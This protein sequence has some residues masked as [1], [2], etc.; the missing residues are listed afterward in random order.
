VVFAKVDGE[1]FTAF[2]VER[3]TPGLSIGA[4]EHKL[5]IRGSS[6]C[7]LILE[8]AAVPVGNVLG[9]IGKGHRIAFNI[10]NVGRL[11]LGS[12]VAGGMKYQ[13][14]Q[15]LKYAQERQ[16][17][18]SPIF[19]FGLI[20]EKFARMATWTYAVESMAYRTSGLID[21][22]LAGEDPKATDYDRKTIAAIEEYAVEASILK[23]F[24]SEAVGMVVDEAVQIHGGYGFIED[25]AVARAY[26]DVRINRIFEGTNEI[27]RLLITGMLLKR[28]FSRGLPLFDF[29]QA[30]ES[31]LSSRASPQ[32]RG[33]DEVS[34]EALVAEHLKRLAVY[35]LKL[36]A[37]A[38]GPKIEE[39]QSVLA[40]IADIVMD[41]FALD[42][43]VARARQSAG[44]GAI[45][46]VAVA[47][48]QLFALDAQPKAFDRAR[49]VICAA[50]RDSDPTPQLERLAPLFH[51]TPRD[52]SRLEETIAQRVSDAGGYPFRLD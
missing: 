39:R 40:W 34:P 15:A 43:M 46:P 7:P 26:R 12:A 45:D 16:Q 10:L 49:R 3:G 17:F 6:T 5:G 37:E 13:L 18:G 44:S 42:S 11:K 22:R 19:N 30:V 24:G 4:E 51:S 31:E 2:I 41:A 38:F 36:A 20:R 29:A 25:F 14:E 33:G 23:V 9:E 1:K 8:N 21:A 47:M 28:A 35:P 50:S 27:N 52:A 48:I 32:V